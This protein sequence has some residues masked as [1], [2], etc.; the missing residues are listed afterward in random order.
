MN[1]ELQKLFLDSAFEPE[2]FTEQ[3]LKQIEQ[4]KQI[5]APANTKKSVKFHLK[6]EGK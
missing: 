3:E 5:I 6:I 2:D 4:T 1:I